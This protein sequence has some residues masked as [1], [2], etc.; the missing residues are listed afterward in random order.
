MKK[1]LLLA[2]S[3]LLFTMLLDAG[4]ITSHYRLCSI[5]CSRNAIDTTSVGSSYGVS[6]TNISVE[7][8]WINRRISNRSRQ[9][10]GSYD[11]IP[12]DS[13][14]FLWNFIGW[15][16]PVTSQ[17]VAAKTIALP[18]LTVILHQVAGDKGT[19]A[20]TLV[21]GIPTVNGAAGTTVVG[22][23]TLELSVFR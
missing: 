20:G 13:F 4:E 17:T 21:T 16:Y 6:G 19:L 10:V 3:S 7:N 11:I 9:S 22:Q 23:R 1:L 18:I 14:Q 8:G 15:W 12:M 2:S 5:D